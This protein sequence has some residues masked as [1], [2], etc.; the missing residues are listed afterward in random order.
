MLVLVTLV[1]LAEMAL[2]VDPFGDGDDAAV[3]V[4]DSRVLTVPAGR[5]VLAA[6]LQ[7]RDGV[8][9][10][11]KAAQELVAVDYSKYDEEVARAVDLTTERYEREYRQT[12]G[13]VR[14]EAVAQKLVV[15]ANVVGQGV[16]RAS[17][18]RLEAL[19]FLNQVVSRVRDGKPETVLTPYKV[20]VT[21][22][23]T[24]NGWLVDGLETDEP[25]KPGDKQDKTN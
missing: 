5:P 1:L 20:L 3:E 4:S 16:V 14:E 15:Q 24:D 10:A 21:V 23:H 9:A 11:A 19:I 12:I 17:R 2:L 8:A 18:T 6:E 25:R 22:V 13:D 7:V